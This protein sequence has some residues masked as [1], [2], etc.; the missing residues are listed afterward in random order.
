MHLSKF[1]RLAK[2]AMVQI[3][4]SVEDERTFFNL[5]F[6]NFKLW[7]QLVGHSNIFAYDLLM[8]YYGLE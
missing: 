2:L 1:T 7:N 8:C 3:V 4:D 6:R 5:F